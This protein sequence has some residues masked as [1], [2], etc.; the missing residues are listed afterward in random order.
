MERRKGGGSYTYLVMSDLLQVV[1]ES[2]VKVGM[3]I[4]A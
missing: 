3:G 1:E 2:N 4:N